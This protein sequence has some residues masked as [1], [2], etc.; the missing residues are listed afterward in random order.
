MPLQLDLIGD[1][2]RQQANTLVKTLQGHEF[3]EQ[4][5]H[6]LRVVRHELRNVKEKQM[7]EASKSGHPIDPAITAGVK[8]LLDSNDLPITFANVNWMRHNLVYRYLAPCEIL[9]IGWICRR[10]IPCK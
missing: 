3:A 10:T 6:I 5:Q 2:Q 9:L 8:V 4:L 7:A 1:L